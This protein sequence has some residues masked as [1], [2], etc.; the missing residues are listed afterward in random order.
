MKKS[1][2]LF[3][4]LAAFFL[5]P[6]CNRTEKSAE[7]ESGNTEAQDVNWE[8]LP[9]ITPEIQ[10]A[11]EELGIPVLQQPIPMLD[12]SV[13]LADGTTINLRDLTG[14][15]IFLNFWATWCGPCRMEMPSMEA[16]Y[17]RFKEDGLEILAVNVRESQK[18]VKAFM[19]E[20]KLSFPAALDTNGDIAANYAIEA[21]PTTYIIDRNG[22]IIT[23]LVG[24]INW[25]VPELIELFEILLKA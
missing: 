13:T 19:D 11:F 12:F 4:I 9:E 25:D 16:L 2:G 3:I 21:F 22:G 24:A 10:L 14:K 23:R 1:F 8:T 7:P 17:Q 15:L 6:Q 20:Y 18:D 5:F